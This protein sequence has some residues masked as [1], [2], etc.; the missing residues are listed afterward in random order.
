MILVKTRAGQKTAITFIV[1]FGL[2]YN[3]ENSQSFLTSSLLVV[4]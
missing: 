1:R 4:T 2:N 3:P